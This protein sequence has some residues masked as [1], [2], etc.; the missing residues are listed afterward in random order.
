MPGWVLNA[1][2]YFFS[3]TTTSAVLERT[4]NLGPHKFCHPSMKIKTGDWPVLGRAASHLGCSSIYDWI[5]SQS[6][7]HSDCR[8]SSPLLVEAASQWG[9]SLLW[10][11]L[12]RTAKSRPKTVNNKNKQLPTVTLMPK[13]PDVTF[14]TRCGSFHT[15]VLTNKP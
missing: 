6:V 4:W 10:T 3:S 12:I 1:P 2:P 8:H 15:L 5:T 9:T 14:D 7:C 13:T 11:Y